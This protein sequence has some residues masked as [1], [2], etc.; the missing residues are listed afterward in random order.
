MTHGHVAACLYDTWPCG[1]VATSAHLNMAT[2]LNNF[3]TWSMNTR[4]HLAIVTAI[5]ATW[6]N[7]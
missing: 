2:S 1:D 5:V 3:A 6:R 7:A 4:G